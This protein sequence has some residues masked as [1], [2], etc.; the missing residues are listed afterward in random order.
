MTVQED[1]VHFLRAGGTAEEIVFVMADE[2]DDVLV[3][4]A[5]QND[6]EPQAPSAETVAIAQEE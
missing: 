4:N 2:C 6:T 3:T 1:T 5:C